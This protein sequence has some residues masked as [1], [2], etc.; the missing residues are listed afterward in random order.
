MELEFYGATGTVTGSLHRVRAGGL[1]ILLDCGLYQGHRA[2]AAERNRKLPDFARDADVLILSHAHIDH[3]GNIPSLV[4]RGFQ[5]NIFCTPA[6]RDLASVMLQDSAYIQEQ[7]AKF[8]NKRRDR[9]NK[10][11]GR[12]GNPRGNSAGD[13][14]GNNRPIEPLYTVADA[15]RSLEHFVSVS[16]RRTFRLNKQVDFTFYDAGHIL[17]SALVLISETVGNTKT[18]LLFTGDLGRHDMPILHDPEIID[19]VDYLISESTYGDRVHEPRVAMDEMLAEE[20]LRVVDSRGKVFIPS[21]SLERAQELLL[22]LHRLEAA[23]RIPELPVYLDSPLAIAVTDIFRL[24]PECFDRDLTEMIEN[25]DSPFRTRNLVSVHSREQSMAIMQHEGPAIIIAGSGM[26]ENG[27]IV[28]HLSHGISKVENTVLIVGFQAENTLGRRLKEGARSV[29]IFGEELPVYARVRSLE[30][31]SAH[32][33]SQDLT[34][35][36][37]ELSRRH[38]LKQIFLVHGEE[39]AARA[40]AENLRARLSA[41]VHMPAQG[42]RFDLG[43][44]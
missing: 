17:G 39:H 37:E 8:L 27:R 18:R 34:R 12:G 10:N 38:H 44:I 11:G 40:L 22:S 3:S 2:Q 19:G 30:G 4:K 9:Q 26:C 36:I 23:G 21:F 5:G 6:T 14:G 13:S 16:Y 43:T 42:D 1:D 20:I 7:D 41:T 35:Y 33:D 25:R 32:A 29:K 31:F 24:H 28:H 15:L